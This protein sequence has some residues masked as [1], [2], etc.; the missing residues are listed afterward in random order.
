M[1]QYTH[2]GK[3]FLIFE[4]TLFVE[5][6][7]LEREP[8]VVPEE[9]ILPPVKKKYRRKRRKTESVD[10]QPEP[11]KA[12]RKKRTNLT[13]EQV[14]AVHKEYAEGISMSELATKYGVSASAI[15]QR[16]KGIEQRKVERTVWGKPRPE[17]PKPKIF[18]YE[19]DIGH[20]F[21]SALNFDEI[22]VFCP[23]CNSTDIHHAEPR[24]GEI[25]E[26]ETNG[27]I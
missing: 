7:Q 10:I 12:E 22:D 11:E 25:I 27:T 26:E 20:T 24:E 13:P 6:D 2:G 9:I 3:K 4:D 1:K 23:K 21:R 17:K 16:V 19:C 15:Y 18:D 5:A 8:E 14:A